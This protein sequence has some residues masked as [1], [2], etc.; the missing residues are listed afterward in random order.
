MM[1]TCAARVAAP[2]KAAGT[3]GRFRERLTSAPCVPRASAC[4]GAAVA[5]AVAQLAQS[6]HARVTPFALPSVSPWVG[7]G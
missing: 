2:T 5:A 1:E 6:R 4:G 7:G 3:G